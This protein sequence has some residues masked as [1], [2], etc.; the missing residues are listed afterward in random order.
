MTSTHDL[1]AAVVVTEKGTK[2]G[3]EIHLFSPFL[4]LIASNRK[5]RNC[6]T[7]IHTLARCT[8]YALLPPPKRLPM[9][10]RT[11]FP[12]A[13]DRLR[14][15]KVLVTLRHGCVELLA[16]LFIAIIS[17]EIEFCHR[18]SIC[19][20]IIEC[21]QLT[22]ETSVTA[23]Q[24]LVG[25]KVAVDIE[26]GKAVHALELFEAV[27]RHFGCTSDELQQLGLF[28]LVEAADCAPEPLHLW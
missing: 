14:E 4:F 6:I 5:L 15:T 18:V 27:E 12:S 21:L 28:F 16:E 11:I 17:R 13:N 10:L 23:G 24:S 26:L 9:L 1:H 20:Y 19:V 7:Y 3:T 22:I 8:M 2:R 25:A